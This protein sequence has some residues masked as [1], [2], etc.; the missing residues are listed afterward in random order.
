M[1]NLSNNTTPADQAGGPPPVRVLIVDD[2]EMFMDGI[3][4]LLGRSTGIVV[5][6]RCIDDNT[7]LKTLSAHPVDLI[8]LDISLPGMSGIELCKLIKHGF[9]TAK[10]LFLTMHNEESIVRQALEN[11]ADGYL[12]KNTGGDMLVE[13]IRCIADGGSYFSEE[14]ADILSGEPQKISRYTIVPK[15]SRR[16]KEILKLIVEEYTTQE[17]AEKLF[18]S[19]KTV[20]ATRSHLFTKVNAR[21]MAG[22]VKAALQMKLIE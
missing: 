20:E 14:V 16:E 10:I 15:I 22:L 19:V 5:Q 2:H 7:V 6:A 8:L 17:I 13:A 3:A 4:L 1:E 21:N 12:L 18:L 9:P 11:G